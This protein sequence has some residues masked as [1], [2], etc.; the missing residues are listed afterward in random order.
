MP[1]NED[2]MEEAYQATLIN[3]DERIIQYALSLIQDSGMRVD[4]IRDFMKGYYVNFFITTVR[5]IHFMRRNRPIDDNI[6]FQEY[7]KKITSSEK[8]EK[9]LTD[10]L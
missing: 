2:D 8:L 10:L 4:N 1:T 5:N 9:I 7:L 6:I 3:M